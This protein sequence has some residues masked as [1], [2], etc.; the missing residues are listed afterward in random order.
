MSKPW[1]LFLGG[2]L[3]V[4]NFKA[5][6]AIL[7]TAF[8]IVV[9][10][11]YAQMQCICHSKQP[12]MRRMHE[13][14]GMTGCGNCHKQNENLMSKRNA[15]D[16]ATKA[17][18]AKRIREDESCVPCHDSQ[19]AIKKEIHS[20]KSTMGISGTLYCPKDK[21]RFSPDIKSCS[22][23]G[24]ILLNIDEIMTK[25]RKSPS[26]EICME[27]HRVEEVQQIERHTIFNNEKL[28]KCL[29]CHKGHDDCGSCHH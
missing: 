24:G 4:K 14:I 21:L 15:K 12:A 5:Y 13:T 16:S 6:S 7:L 1:V 3:P 11:S 2:K 23:C 26:N 27:C 19:G 20:S 29:D 22:K 9:S 28:R 18:L 25:S 10:P 8:I 17:S